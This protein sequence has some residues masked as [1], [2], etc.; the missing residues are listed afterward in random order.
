VTK[1]EKH[2]CKRCEEGVV[3][4]PPARII[5]KSL[6]RCC[7]SVKKPSSPEDDRVRGVI[8]GL[9]LGCDGRSLGK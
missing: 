8:A 5:E 9:L 2:A 7:L 4:A 3:A 6:K 1:L